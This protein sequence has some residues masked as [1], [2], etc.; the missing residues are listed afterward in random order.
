MA[1]EDEG[2]VGIVIA[3]DVAKYPLARRGVHAGSGAAWPCWFRKKIP[4]C[5]AFEQ[6]YGSFTRDENDFFRPMGCK[7]AVVNGKHSNQCYL[8]AMR[9]AYDSFAAKAKRSGAITPGAGESITDFIDH[10]LFH[11][12][13][14]RMVEYASAAIFGMTGE[15][16][17][18]QP[19]RRGAW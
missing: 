16:A 18:V 19:D 10:L 12:P 5:L 1:A 2:K 4:S 15:S 9:G 6:I 11:I 8:D 7:T 3:S 13:Y 14:P 17:A